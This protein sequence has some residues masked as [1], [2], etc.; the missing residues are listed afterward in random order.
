M[1]RGKNI[2]IS[3]YLEGVVSTPQSQL[4]GVQGLMENVS[5]GVVETAR[6]LEL[7]VDPGVPFV[8]QQKRTLLVSMRTWV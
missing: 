8:V 6:E 1:G 3:W 7:K 4:R 5:T 2:N